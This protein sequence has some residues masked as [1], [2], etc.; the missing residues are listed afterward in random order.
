MQVKHL[1]SKT[2]TGLK[3]RTCNGD[4]MNSDTGKITQ[5]WQ[6]FAELYGQHLT[7]NTKVYGVYTNYQSDVSGE[8]DVIACCDQPPIAT[9]NSVTVT[10]AAGNYLVF[11]SKGA[12]PDA[13]INL[14]GEIWQYFSS[15]DC[16][17]SRTYQSDYEYYKS[18]DEIEIAIAIK[19]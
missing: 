16:R 13:V 8:F 4:E 19:E 11:S 2:L 3:V 10:T 7:K 14:W 6:D 15:D 17:Y 1:P 18:A 12:M 5:L 9:E